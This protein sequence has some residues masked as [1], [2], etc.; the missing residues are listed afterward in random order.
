MNVR[1]THADDPP[2]ATSIHVRS[3]D[4]HC[5]PFPQSM[6]ANAASPDALV[7]RELYFAELSALLY[8]TSEYGEG[9]ELELLLYR[10][11]ELLLEDAL[12]S[13]AFF[14]VASCCFT[15][16]E[17][18]RARLGWSPLPRVPTHNFCQS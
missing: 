8:A 15:V 2:Q 6:L 3:V 4:L 13:A 12:T 9:L 7:Q 10:L 11:L 17:R 14:K 5:F 18:P 16:F 1:D